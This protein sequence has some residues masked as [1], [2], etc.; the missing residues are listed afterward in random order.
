MAS[1][2]NAQALQKVPYVIKI[3][4]NY[5][6]SKTTEHPFSQ[7]GAVG[8]ASS[9]NHHIQLQEALAWLAAVLIY[10]LL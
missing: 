2:A 8:Q 9:L 4:L 5:F 10:E 7:D 3:H 1:P 6:S